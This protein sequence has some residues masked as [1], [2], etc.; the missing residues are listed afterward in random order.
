MELSILIVDDEPLAR[1]RLERLVA[2]EPDLRLAGVCAGGRE[3]IEALRRQPPDLVL[4]DVAM[5][6]VGGF[7][8]I[9]AVGLE[10]M[11]EVIFVTAHG[12]HALRAFEVHALDYLLKPFTD[13]RFR[14][15]IVAARERI[16]GPGRKAARRLEV[17]LDELREPRGADRLLVRGPESMRFVPTREIRWIDAA[18][19]YVVLRTDQGSFRQRGTLASLED[20][21]DPRRFLRIHRSTLVNLDRVREIAPTFHGDYVA[22]LDCGQRL[23]VGRRYK[24]RLLAATEAL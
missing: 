19:N 8:V 17:L 7:D 22:V 3:A 20:R 4:L 10:R 5:P 9:E 24:D 18:D 11:P 12:D 2:E 1:R 6:E 14:R 15:A 21:L 23:A 13:E 16:A